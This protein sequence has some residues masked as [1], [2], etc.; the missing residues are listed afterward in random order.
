M[1]CLYCGKELA[2]L[3]RWTGGGEFCSDAHRQRYQEEYNQLA[4]NRLL[5]AKPPANETPQATEARPAKPSVVAEPSREVATVS[6]PRVAAPAPEPASLKVSEKVSERPKPVYHEAPSS[7]AVRETT[8]D[9][10]PVVFTPP[11]V[12]HVEPEPPEEPGPA[13]LAGFFVEMPVV[14]EAEPAP[15]SRPDVDFLDA[16]AA[17]LPSYAFEPLNFRRDTYQLEAAGLV[18]FEPSNRASNYVGSGSRERRLEVRDFVR[19]APVVEIELSA[20]GET[21]LETSSEAMDI[22]I[23]PQPPEGAQVLWQEPPVGFAS[24]GTEL[25]DLARLSFPSTGF[26]GQDE[27]NHDETNREQAGQPETNSAIAVEEPPSEVV[28][29]KPPVEVAAELFPELLAEVVP[30]AAPLPEPVL[31]PVAE[32]AVEE[33][34]DQLV[35]PVAEPVVE[36]MVEPVA[37]PVVE[38]AVEQ[39]VEPAPLIPD[40]ITKPLPLSLHLVSPGKGKLV[41]VFSSAANAVEAQVPR[42]T[43]LPLRPVMMLGPA[44]APLKSEARTEP[45]PEPKKPFAAPSPVRPDPRVAVGKLR[46]LNP[47][48]QDDHKPP[49]KTAVPEAVKETVPALKQVA[50][51]EISGASKPPARIDSKQD[52]KQEAKETVRLK[53]DPKRGP[54]PPAPL[55]APFPGS[56]ELGLPRLNLQSSSGFLGQLPVVA[57]IG[58]VVVLLAGLGGLIAF[59]SKS[60]GAAVNTGAGT[61]VAGSALPSGE[62]GWITDW[63]ADP[64]VRRTRQ[65]SIL[66]SSQTLTDYRIEMNGQ[67]ESKA[68]GWVFRAADP[69][70]FYVT[71]LEIVKPGLEPTVALV[72]FAIINGEEQAHAQ[73]PL[74]INARLDTMYKIRFDAVGDHFTTYVQDEKVDDWTDDRVKTGGV[75]FYRERGED[76]TLKGGM[77]VVPLV[78]KK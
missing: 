21:G 16:A 17:A 24:P 76:A 11:A 43:S 48:V 38:Q 61:V 30:Q 49:V 15:M 68:I 78:V 32:Q 28:P 71:K 25:G 45:K 55:A 18:T 69:K 35:E 27:S 26:S 37:E 75:G 66:R 50:K 57:K 12:V 56:N 19:S 52:K 22:L 41:Q 46:G 8:V 23:F 1:R 40:L 36:H 72:R 33:V 77:S 20:A 73:L 64:G 42:S 54:V 53:E 39:V 29:E 3:K 2:L 59:S 34:V 74:S 14:R 5:Q 60:G 70:N 58:I 65:I 7:V 63:G 44:P 51:S 4:L 47:E 31:S 13:D 10:P 9:T 67:I 6:A 62:A